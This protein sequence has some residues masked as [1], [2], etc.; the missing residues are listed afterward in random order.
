MDRITTYDQAI[1]PP[2]LY[3]NDSFVFVEFTKQL[4]DCSIMTDVKLEMLSLDNISPAAP[5]E[6]LPVSE[7]PLLVLGR[8]EVRH[9][10]CGGL[11]L[12]RGRQRGP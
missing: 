7:C 4:L 2:T 11:G 1:L 5:V 3:S 6:P 10:P 9:S 12:N 8:A